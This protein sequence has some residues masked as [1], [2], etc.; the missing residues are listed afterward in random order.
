MRKRIS[1]VW[2]GIAVVIAMVVPIFPT[3]SRA[4]FRVVGV[5]IPLALVAIF[6]VLEGFFL[7]SDYVARWSKAHDITVTPENSKVLLPY[8]RRG[9]A[10]RATGAFVGYATYIIW[11]DITGHNPPGFATWVPATFGGYLLGAAIAE[12]WAFRPQTNAP[13]AATLAPRQISTYV[14]RVAVLL[15]R[16]ATVAIVGLTAAWRFIPRDIAVFRGYSL[17]P[18]P[19]L[20]ATLVWT[21]IAIVLAVLVEGTARRIVRR[22]QPAVSEVFIEADDAIRSTAMHGLVG[23]GLALEFGILSW[24]ASH[25]GS[26]AGGNWHAA[27]T[28]VSLLSGLAAVFAWL[29]LGIDQKWVVRRTQRRHEV[30]A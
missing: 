27:L 9:R 6:V 24:Q 15:M 22:P 7:R 3:S 2:V 20:G 19:D 14:P 25:Q 11:V 1:I 13:H 30:A 29:H 16:L 10:I 8:L 17:A 21:G 4:S 23:A 18:R 12:F 28:S 26:L 5:A